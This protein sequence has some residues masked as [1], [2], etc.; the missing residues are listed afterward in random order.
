MEKAKTSFDGNKKLIIIAA[1][2]AI[3]VIAY[4]VVQFALPKGEGKTGKTSEGETAAGTPVKDAKDVFE[5]P[6]ADIKPPAL[7]P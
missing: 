2:V 6:P 3:L 5:E 1:A 4:L 7:P